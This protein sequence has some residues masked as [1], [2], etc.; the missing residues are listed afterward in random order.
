MKISDIKDKLSHLYK[1]KDLVPKLLSI[2]LALIIWIYVNN[3]KIGQLE[4]KIRIDFKNFS[5]EYII[6]EQEQKYVTV[7]IEGN[8]EEI[9]NI[10]HGSVKAYIDLT[11]P[12]LNQPFKYT[13]R[14]SRKEIPDHIEVYLKEKSVFL[15][16]EKKIK[17]EVSIVPN[18]GGSISTGYFIGNISIDPPNVVISGP[19]S[20]ISKI[21]NINTELISV[22]GKEDDAEG[23]IDLLNPKVGLISISKD[24]VK[25]NVPIYEAKNV[26]R[27]ELPIQVR[28]LPDG[29]QAEIKPETV[30]VYVKLKDSIN[31]TK[32]DT[33]KAYVEYKK[34]LNN[35]DKTSKIMIDKSALRDASIIIIKPEYAVVKIVE[36]KVEEDK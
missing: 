1:N 27:T 8:K 5:N 6:T 11:E 22:E 10:N 15:R 16:V 18:F 34:D 12:I 13:V 33:I 7:V 2:L 35:A 28:N 32:I 30:S 17:K 21:E 31:E 3:K 19:E 20:L 36:S 9:K 4:F 26:S 25:Y 24:E 23:V 29:Y 14:L